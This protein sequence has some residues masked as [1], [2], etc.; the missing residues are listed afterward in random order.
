[1]FLDGLMFALVADGVLYLKTDADTR[2]Q[3]EQR[4]L[5]AFTV[6]QRGK[7]VNMGYYAAP[8]ELFDDPDAAARWAGLAIDAARRTRRP[9]AKRRP[10]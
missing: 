7:V 8:D 6:A 3:F 9:P 2:A 5:Q 4:G 1:M 10:R